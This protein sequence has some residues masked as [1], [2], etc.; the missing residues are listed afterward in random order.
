MFFVLLF[1]LLT[2]SR[3]VIAQDIT[4]AVTIYKQGKAEIFKI[5]E[6]IKQY[7][8]QVNQI[9]DNIR[10]LSKNKS[11]IQREISK[12]Q[13]VLNV[14]RQQILV[15]QN[16]I[17]IDI[18]KTKHGLVQN[19]QKLKGNSEQYSLT[20]QQIDQLMSVEQSIS[21]INKADRQ[22]RDIN[23]NLE[24]ATLKA[25]HKKNVMQSSSSTEDAKINSLQSQLMNLKTSLG[26]N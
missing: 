4:Q 22:L 1:V 10:S 8:D 18:G 7:K 25:Q 11:D 21:G 20:K 6:S 2:V 13:Q 12:L 9:N 23:R 26:I 5:E 14:K 3:I 19:L 24:F 15:M 17:K 16:N